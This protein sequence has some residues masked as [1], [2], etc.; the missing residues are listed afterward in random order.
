VRADADAGTPAA[1]AHPDAPAAQAVTRIAAD[2]LTRLKT[3]S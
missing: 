2:L 3:G 1:I